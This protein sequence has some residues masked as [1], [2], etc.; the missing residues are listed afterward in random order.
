MPPPACGGRPGGG[1]VEPGP[2]GTGSGVEGQRAAGSGAR[3]A[4]YEVARDAGAA[5]YTAADDRDDGDRAQRDE[6]AEQGVLDQVLPLVLTYPP[7]KKLS[8]LAPRG[9]TPVLQFYFHWKTLSAIAGVTWWNF[10]FLLFPGS[11]LSPQVVIFLTHLLRDLPGDV[12]VIWDG[13]RQHRSRLE[14]EFLPA[15][16]P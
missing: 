3:R 6:A 15:Y 4:L 7:K 10:Y 14:L 1:D 9:R 8:H 16:A 13:L 11:I 5:G 2:A 12:L